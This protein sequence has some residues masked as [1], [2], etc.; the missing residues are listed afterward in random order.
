MI[1]KSKDFLCF[2]LWFCCLCPL[3]AQN[4]GDVLFGENQVHEVYIHFSQPAYWD[5]LTQYYTLDLYLKGDITIDGEFFAE[6][7][8]KFKGNSSYNNPSVK[9]PFKVDM[10]A[11]VSGQDVDGL[12]KF[13][14]NNGFKDPT[15]IREKLTL[16]FYRAHD[17]PAPRCTYARVYLNNTY[18]G[19]YTLVEEADN[20]TFLKQRFGNKDGNLY[21]GDPK[22]DLRWLGNNAVSYYDK[23]ELKN[24]E[25]INDW[26]D[27]VHLID[28]INNTNAQFHDSLES[29]LNT[30]HFINQWA[31]TNLFVN[32]DSYIGSGHNYFI[33]HNTESGKFEWI[34]W[35][36]NESFGNFQMGLQPAQVENLSFLF[37]SNPP[38]RP[39]TQKMSQLQAYKNQLAE[40]LCSWIESDFSNEVLNPKIDS[41]ANLIRPYVYSDTKKFYSNQQFETNLSSNV[42]VTGNPGGATIFGLKSFINNRRTALANELSAYCLTGTVESMFSA[43]GMYPNPACG[44]VTLQGDMPIRLIRVYSLLG[45]LVMEQKNSA[46]RSLDV[47][48]LP[49]GL[50]LIQVNEQVYGKLEVIR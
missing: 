42:T 32:L 25:D 1:T 4:E 6:V 16:D 34:A 50:Y 9:K 45:E 43:P 40:V 10:N 29:V 3:M 47:S 30:S 48:A 49:A 24:N 7:G 33:Y 28:N 35:D 12:K 46:D 18:W 22:G 14:L 37:M 11:Y 38:S 20:G 17:I 41:L 8:I 39:L 2:V 19:L 36:V 26:S 44:L 21:K 31:A 5:S 23:Y 15:F 27:L 13:N